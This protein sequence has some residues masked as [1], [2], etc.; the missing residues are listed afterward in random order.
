[1]SELLTEDNSQADIAALEV[2]TELRRH[3]VKVY[4]LMAVGLLISAVVAYWLARQASVTEYVQTHPLGFQILFIFEMIVVAF[5]SKSIDKLSLATTAAIFFGYA[6]L[7]GVTFAVFFIWLPPASV[8]SGFALTAVTFA[9]TALYGHQTGQDLGA[10]RSFF[11]MVGIGVALLVAVN[12]VLQNS[13]AYWA[14]AYMGVMAFGGL[15][16]YHSQD[17]R[18][19]EWEFEDD[20]ADRCKAMYASALTLYLDFVNL[21]ALI[22]RLG[23]SGR[24]REL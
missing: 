16:T 19:L 2:E 15:S 21:Y 22:M 8:A 18:D 17:L 5:V 10:L 11:I 7:N 13:V 4:A 24:D 3:L 9:L 20:D 1:M 14:T 6:L 12:L 23:E